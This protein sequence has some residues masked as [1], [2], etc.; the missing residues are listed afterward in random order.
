MDPYNPD[1]PKLPW[2]VEFFKSEDGEVLNNQLEAAFAS[3]ALSHLSSLSM[4]SKASVFRASQLVCT[5]P[6]NATCHTIE[7][8][9]SLGMSVARITVPGNQKDK[10]LEMIA[11]VR[12]LTE[13]FSKKIGRIYPL[14]LAIDVRGPEIRI[15]K[16]EKNRDS[17]YLPKGKLT[18][19]TSDEAYEEFVN[20]DMIF[21]DYQKLSEIIQPGDKVL[22]DYGALH[23]SA[24]EVAESIVKCIVEKAGTLIGRSSVI[25]PNAPIDLPVI[26]SEDMDILKLAIDNHIDYIVVSG[27]YSK[28]NI[29]DIKRLVGGVDTLQILTKIENSMAVD[30][31]NEIID[32][33]DGVCIDCERL[34]FDIPKEKVFLVQKSILAKCNLKGIPV[35]CSTNI[36]DVTTLSKSEVCDIANCIIDGAD[37]LLINQSVCTKEIVKEVSVICKEAEPAVYQRQIFNELIYNIPTPNESIY[38]L[39]ISAVEASLKT[40]AAAIICLT[41]SGRTAKLI[42]RFKPRCPLIVITRYPRVARLLRLY[43]SIDPIIYLKAFSGNYDHDL[44]DRVQ[45]GITYGKLMGYIKMGDSLV[46]VTGSRPEAGIPNSMKILYASDYDTLLNKIRY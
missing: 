46:T 39:C 5:L 9:M 11:K 8:L 40:S 30:N 32:E 4:K 29:S 33:S 45:L 42:S 22:I 34:L 2:M 18:A 24:I 23:L 1:C 3:T 6:L 36:A 26:S 13:R 28:E 12:V 43:K 41:T 15:G 19:L 27:I 38:S 20:E 25:I 17:L 44:E 16:L 37:G 14:A 10:I 7:E 21:V 31:I 35:I